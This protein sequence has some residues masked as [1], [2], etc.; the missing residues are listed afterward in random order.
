MAFRDSRSGTVNGKLSVGSDCNMFVKDPNLYDC[1][2]GYE[3]DKGKRVPGCKISL[4]IEMDNVKLCINDDHYGRTGFGLLDTSLK[5][6]AAI[7]QVLEC[8]GI[9]WRAKAGK[10]Q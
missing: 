1:L 8:N 6:S 7:E 9:E 4:W 3:S 10:R 2:A 5:L